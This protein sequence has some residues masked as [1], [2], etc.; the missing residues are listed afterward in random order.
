MT[1]SLRAAHASNVGDVSLF[2]NAV[3]SQGDTVVYQITDYNSFSVYTAETTVGTISITDDSVTLVMPPTT[4]ETQLTMNIIKDGRPNYFV[5]AIGAQ[6]IAAPVITSPLNNA[7]SVSLSVSIQT[8]GFITVPAG[9]DTHASTNWQIATDNLFTNL[10]V[11]VTADTVNKVVFPVPS[12][13]L[14]INTDYYVRASFNGA[15]MGTSPWSA[16]VKFTTRSQYIQTPILNVQDGPDYVGEAPTLTGSAFTVLGGGSD[17]HATSDW[18]VVD[19]LTSAVVWQ[20]L[21]NSANKTS[22]K[23]PAGLLLVSTQY[24]ARMRYA[25]ATLGYGGWAELNFTTTSQFSYGEYMLFE[26]NA[27]RNGVYVPAPA[28]VHMLGRKLSQFIE[29]P[30]QPSLP[31]FPATT[32]P[33]YASLAPL[34]A[35]NQAFRPDGNYLVMTGYRSNCATVYKRQNDSFDRLQLPITPDNNYVNCAKWVNN[36]ILLVGSG[37][38]M[39]VY[40]QIGDQF[41]KLPNAPYTHSR[42]YQS[43]ENSWGMILVHPSGQYVT[44][45]VCNSSDYVSSYIATWK[46]S[47]TGISTTFTLVSGGTRST[48]RTTGC[49]VWTADGT[50]LFIGGSGSTVSVIYKWESEVLTQVWVPT[51][52]PNAWGAA[53]SPDAGYLVLQNSNEVTVYQKVQGS[54]AYTYLKSIMSGGNGSGG[55]HYRGSVQFTADGKLLLG[56]SG[57]YQGSGGTTRQRLGV[58]DA[59]TSDFNPVP[60]LD[61]I[62]QNGASRIQLYPFVPGSM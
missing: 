53:F 20:S 27:M 5:V 2:G 62:A 10:V 52:S 19:V 28:G 11:N 35:G 30:N 48:G 9:Q 7:T 50:R 41:V 36:D 40:C 45:M 47:G 32:S 60:A 38:N 39:N 55:A 16:P 44:A 15:L 43:N 22:I 54:E 23:V 61:M 26:G 56:M 29:I 49:M 37:M 58:F 42:D 24:R 17:V 6:S 31:P 1:I 25:G 3:V 46:I 33:Y 4:A 12:S 14:Q 34:I 8:D 57:E 18:Q 13:V 51:Y 59:T 21:G